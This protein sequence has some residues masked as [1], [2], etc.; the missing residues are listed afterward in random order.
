MMHD[1]AQIAGEYEPP[2]ITAHLDEYRHFSFK[3]K[4]PIYF[5]TYVWNYVEPLKKVDS[6]EKGAIECT[7]CYEFYMEEDLFSL[8]C[9]HSFCKDCTKEHIQ[10]NIRNPSILCM[11][12][13]CPRNFL[14]SHLHDLRMT[15]E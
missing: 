14:I 6:N 7:V 15:P 2:A 5:E 9:K 3:S 1:I 12:K 10:T 11:Q 4:Q 8:N 13:D